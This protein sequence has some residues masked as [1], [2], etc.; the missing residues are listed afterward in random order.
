[1]NYFDEQLIQHK[2]P[3]PYRGQGRTGPGL[4]AKIRSAQKISL[5]TKKCFLN[6][7]GKVLWS[8][9]IWGPSLVRNFYARPKAP[10]RL[11]TALQ[12]KRQKMKSQGRAIKIISDTLGGSF[13]YYSLLIKC[14]KFSVSFFARH[15]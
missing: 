12:K 1:M 8:S 10:S 9:S 14:L 2:K 13:S 15:L 11:G 4:S 3:G 7:A 6:T 5:L